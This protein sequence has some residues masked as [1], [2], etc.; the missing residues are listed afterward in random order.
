MRKG[1]IMNNS[2]EIA[3]RIRKIAKQQG[4]SITEM[5]KYCELSKN[6]LSSMQAGNLP[7]IE[8]LA[9]I[10]DYL[11]TS[12]DYLLGRSAGPGMPGLEKLCASLADL[13]DEEADAVAL[14]SEFLQWK[15]TDKSKGE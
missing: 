9:K 1:V 5:L 6:A 2:Q 14:Y 8:N 15:R 11:G 4:K 13:T 3:E 7:R 10:A 12:I